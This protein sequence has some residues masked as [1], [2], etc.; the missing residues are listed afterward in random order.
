ME[1]TRMLESSKTLRRYIAL[2][3]L[4]VTALVMG[5]YAKT[6]LRREIEHGPSLESGA[7]VPIL[8]LPTTDGDLFDLH[9]LAATNQL[10]VVTFWASWCL[11]CRVELHQLAELYTKHSDDGL[12]VLAVS[13]DAN[14]HELTAFLKRRPMPFTVV[15]DREREAA[16]RYG[17]RSLPTTILIDD[18]GR[19]RKVYEG[20]Q[21][22]LTSR[23]A[24]LLRPSTEDA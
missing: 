10:V 18:Q 14:A 5:A 13:L 24:R 6:E 4:V 7:A 17:I 8:R 1:R 2:A 22:G 21:K 11:P 3:T 12:A 15:V 19:V 20:F 16:T 9:R 23:I